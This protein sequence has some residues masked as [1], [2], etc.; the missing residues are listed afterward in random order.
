M[1]LMVLVFG[2]LVIFLYLHRNPYPL[3]CYR[4]FKES[5]LTALL[6]AFF[7]CEHSGQHAAVRVAWS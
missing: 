2:P 6:H 7:R 3:I 5:G 4:C 1:L